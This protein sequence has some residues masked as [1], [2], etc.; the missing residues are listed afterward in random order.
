M[1]NTAQM[2]DAIHV[3]PFHLCS[4]ILDEEQIITSS[5]AQEVASQKSTRTALEATPATRTPISNQQLGQPR[6]LAALQE[7][8]R[9]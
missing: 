3:Q 5:A 1:L 9:T 7:V 4:P 2:R 8:A 6:R